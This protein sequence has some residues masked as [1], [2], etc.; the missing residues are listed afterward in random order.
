MVHA[1]FLRKMFMK[2]ISDAKNLK[3]NNFRSN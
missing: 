3:K 2:P 1:A